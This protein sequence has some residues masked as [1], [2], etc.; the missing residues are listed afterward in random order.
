[1]K[2]CVDKPIVSIVIPCYNSEKYLS[3]CLDSILSNSY[4]NIEIICIND[5][6]TDLTQNILNEYSKNDIRIICLRQDNKGLS[7]ARNKGL[8][9]V[10]S[11]SSYVLFIDSDDYI[12]NDYIETLVSCA[13]NDK[14]DIVVSSFFFS[15]DNNSNKAESIYE[16]IILNKQEA[17]T[18]LYDDSF[19]HFYVWQKIYKKQLWDT[20]R[21]PMDATYMEDVATSPV[22]FLHA[23]KISV[24]PY[25]GYHYYQSN[26]S[27][28][29]KSGFYNSKILTG[30]NSFKKILELDYS[31]FDPKTELLLRNKAVNLFADFYL[32]LFPRLELKNNKKEI[33]EY[34][35]YVKDN[36]II[37]KFEAKTRKQK[38]KKF[39][40]LITPKLLLLLF[41][42]LNL[43]K[44]RK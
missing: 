31:V 27:S 26:C 34:I 17:I 40:Y 16:H 9:N 11:N 41:W 14:S 23:N 39:S 13:E 38:I 1:M 8:D 29:M 2:K 15:S 20:L 22:V 6:S 3:R 24:I 42:V 10:S 30:Y 44:D 33:C 7:G 35:R 21:F 37:N 43:F 25:A 32:E 36:K 4:K 5:G 12:D 18:M 19:I 28:L